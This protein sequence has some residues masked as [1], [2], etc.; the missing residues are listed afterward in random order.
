MTY[1]DG[2]M[3]DLPR[4]VAHLRGVPAVVLGPDGVNRGVALTAHEGLGGKV[5]IKRG[6]RAVLDLKV[7]ADA[8]AVLVPALQHY[9][10]LAR[11]RR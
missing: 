9:G 4:F 8:R 2:E 1:W 10:D 6:H 11:L 7:E 3:L 5:K